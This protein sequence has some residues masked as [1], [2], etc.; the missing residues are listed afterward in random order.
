MN[1]VSS[2]GLVVL[3]IAC[4]GVGFGLGLVSLAALVRWVWRYQKYRRHY[5]AHN[6]RK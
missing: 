5:I 6:G 2:E 1:L 4:I 3:F